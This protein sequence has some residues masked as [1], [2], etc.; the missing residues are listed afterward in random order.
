METAKY[1]AGQYAVASAFRVGEAY[2]NFWKSLLDSELPRGLNDEEERVYRELLAEQGAP[3]REKAL[4]SYEITLKKAQDRAVFNEWV[5]TTY[6][7]LASLDPGRYPPMLQDSVIWEEAW[8]AKRSLIRTIDRSQPRAFSSKEAET[9]QSGLDKILGALRNQMKEGRLDRSQLLEAVRLLQELLKKEPTLY[10]VRF[11]LGILYQILGETGNARQEYLESLKQ[12]PR[13]QVAHLNLGLLELEEGD[14]KAAERHFK[15]LSSLSPKYAGAYFLL[16]VCK[17][18]RGEYAKAIDP[19]EK[20]IALLPQF[21]DPYVEL[22][23]AQAKLGQEEEAKKNYL[24]VLDN[25]KASPRVLR[26][27]AYHLLEGGW[28]EE[29]ITA[30]TRL[31]HGKEPTYGDWNNRGVAYLRKGELKQ[32]RKEIEQASELDSSRPEA[33]N[34]MGRIYIEGGSYEEALSSFLLALKTDPSFHPALLNAAVVYGQHLDDMDKAMV[35]LQQYLDAGGT[36]QREMFRAWLAGSEKDEE[37][38]PS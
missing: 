37:G 11:N 21:L 10:E 36:M 18:K 33:F 5:L 3:Y 13:N 17:N 34:N 26:M 6:N 31:I 20:A 16:G 24:A 28:I 35:Y 4:S 15:E 7:R 32:A 19:L 27:L 12:H 23:T 30:Y 25:P 8:Q 1:G 2:E 9:L 38:P 29:S 14:L 22:G